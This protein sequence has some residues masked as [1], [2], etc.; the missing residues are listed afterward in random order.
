MSAAAANIL[1]CDPGLNF[2]WAHA[3]GAS[4]CWQL[5]VN[6]GEHAGKRL[7]RLYDHL[8]D[9]EARW[10]ISKIVFEASPM[11]SKG[12]QARDLHGKLTGT[13]LLFAAERDIPFREVV[14]TTIKAFAGHGHY[15]KPEMMRQLKIKLGIEAWDE[16]QADALWLLAYA[17]SG[18]PELAERAQ[19]RARKPPAKRKELF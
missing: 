7:L 1:A 5:S 19:Q 8:A 10:G 2:G 15:K 9:V 3:S 13:L 16:N 14:P 11:V 12:Y 4:G 18:F 6:G 17:Q